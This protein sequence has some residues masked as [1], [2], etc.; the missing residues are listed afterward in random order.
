MKKVLA[1]ALT[2]LVSITALFAADSIKHDTKIHGVSASVPYTA[3]LKYNGVDTNATDIYFDNTNKTAWNL[4]NAGQ[5]S[6][7]SIVF[8]GNENTSPDFEVKVTASPFHTTL[9]NGDA[10]EAPNELKINEK[11]KL[12]SVKAG[13]HQ[14]TEIYKFNISWNGAGNNLT[15]GDYIS[16]VMITYSID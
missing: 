1:I 8:S 5:T 14:D 7:F 13:Y 11:T 16:D 12:E 15:A 6:D 4:Q 9:G 3:K 2:A 10:Y